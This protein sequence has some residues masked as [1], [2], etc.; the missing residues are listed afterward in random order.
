MDSFLGTL[1]FLLPGLMLYFW[2]QSFGINPVVKHTPTEFTAVSV[3]LWFPVSLSSVLVI[4]LLY[5]CGWI[6]GYNTIWTTDDLKNASSG[7]GFIAGFLGLSVIISFLYGW[8][9]ANHLHT[10]FMD[11]INYVRTRR[12]IAKLSKSPSVW[13]ELFLNNDVQVIEMGRIDKADGPTITGCIKKASRTFEPERYLS[14]ENEDYFKRL[15]HDHGIPV[16]NVLYDTKSGSYVK[17]YDTDKIYEAIAKEESES[18]ESIAQAE[19]VTS[20]G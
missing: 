3:L 13:D 15:I 7:L 9:W 4:N 10:V 14:V 12:N 5:S 16:I 11:I 20:S 6:T 2:L 19:E 17:I 8:L 1:I 18:A